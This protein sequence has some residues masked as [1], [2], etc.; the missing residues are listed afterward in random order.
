[1]SESVWDR[2]D[3]SAKHAIFIAQTEA[4]R[5]KYDFILPEHLLIGILTDK[6]SPACAVIRTIGLNAEDILA[7]AK[8]MSAPGKSSNSSEIALSKACK[9][10][11]DHALLDADRVAHHHITTGHLLIGILG[12]GERILLFRAQNDNLARQI[13]H[14][15]GVTLALAQKALLKFDSTNLLRASSKPDHDNNL[16]RPFDGK[17][18]RDS[19][20]LL[21]ST[22]IPN[23]VKQN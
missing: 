13:L 19:D 4:Q 1:M 21:I 12:A 3:G 14:E 20:S 10:I 6:K 5:M 9:R 7:R 15:F 2:Y 23:D 11:V 16:L 17:A 18:D 22:S 8:E